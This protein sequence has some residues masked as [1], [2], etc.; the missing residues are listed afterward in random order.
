MENSPIN[1]GEVQLDSTVK[2]TIKICKQRF[3]EQ[4]AQARQARRRSHVDH[5]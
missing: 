3:V 5:K 4:D 2:I 1:R